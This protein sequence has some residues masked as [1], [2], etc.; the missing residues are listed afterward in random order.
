MAIT[1]IGALVAVLVGT[2]A[3]PPDPAARQGPIVEEVA[4]PS[5]KDRLAGVLYRPATPGPWPAVALVMGSG[6]VDRDYGG[7]GSAIGR[8]FARHGVACLAWDRPGV[9]RSTGDYRGLTF[10]DRAREALAAVAFLRG[11]AEIDRDRVGLW[12]HSQGGMVVPLAASM[13]ADVAFVIEVAGWQGPAWGQ[14]PV[15]VGAELRAEGCR[16]E[17]VEAAVA[18]ARRRMEMIRG[19]GTFEDLDKAQ[20]AVEAAP[21]FG[22]VHRCDRALFDSAR[23]V[24]DHDT[25]ASWEAVR[26]PVLAIF[27]EKDTS[28]GPPGPLVGVIRR[29]LDKAGNRDV[30]VRVFP[31]ADHSLC[32]TNAG[33]RKD[34]AGRAGARAKGDGPDFVP[35]YLDAMTDWLAAR[36]IPRR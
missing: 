15:R 3:G 13:S 6:P 4:F 9:G 29:G 33:G 36:V 24:V 20:A 11:R 8:H 17:D 14:D 23:L 32:R 34:A 10:P 18:F 26:R 30:T 21:W 35:G 16:E 22:H 12:G 2:S 27:G 5:G 19:A 25:S 7:A 1:R 28:S 31:D